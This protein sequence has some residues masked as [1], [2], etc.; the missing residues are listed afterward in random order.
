MKEARFPG[1]LIS[2]KSM[3]KA[4]LFAIF[5]QFFSCVSISGV[6]LTG[7]LDG[8]AQSISEAAQSQ[9]E[10]LRARLEDK[11]ANELIMRAKLLS[12]KIANLSRLKAP[13]SASVSD[14]ALTWAMKD[15]ASSMN[16]ANKRRHAIRIARLRR[17]LGALRPLTRTNIPYRVKK[18]KKNADYSYSKRMLKD[19]EKIAI[20]DG[21]IRSAVFSK[22]KSNPRWRKQSLR[23]SAVHHVSLDNLAAND[24]ANDGHDENEDEI[25]VR[26]VGGCH[27][28][29]APS[30]CNNDALVHLIEQIVTKDVGS[31]GAT[32]PS[33][34]PGM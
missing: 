11:K 13:G 8:F 33:G 18:L 5:L 31:P 22:A 23:V 9:N 32:G 20:D 29:C 21:I 34:I 26:V 24:A 19:D 3:L 4:G 2:N 25:H 17:A 1:E 15:V 12:S 27:S 14:A 30:C 28:G 7:D 6:V 10:Y 16:Q